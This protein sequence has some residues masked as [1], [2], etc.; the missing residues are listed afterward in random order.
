[1]ANC[2]SKPSTVLVSGVAMTPALRTRICSG[3][4]AAACRSTSISPNE[5]ATASELHR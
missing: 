4:P 3:L 2:D 5:I 1:M